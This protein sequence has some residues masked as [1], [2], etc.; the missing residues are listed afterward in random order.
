M[1]TLFVLMILSVFAFSQKPYL[2]MVADPGC[3][4]CVETFNMIKDNKALKSAIRQYTD[5]QVVSKAEALKAGLFVNTTP[6]F[7]FFAKEK[8]ALLVP[9][10]EGKPNSPAEFVRY[11]KEVYK[12]YN[13]TLSNHQFLEK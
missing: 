10:L 1:K 4:T 8:K 6:T 5:L 7:Y 12:K 2:V 13:T 3:P 9:P 11:I